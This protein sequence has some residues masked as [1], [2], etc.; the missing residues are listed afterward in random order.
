[1]KNVQRARYA[2]ILLLINHIGFALANVPAIQTREIERY[3][4]MANAEREKAIREGY[5]R[6]MVGMTPEQVKAILGEPDEIRPLHEPVMKNGKQIGYTHWF[7]I[8]RMVKNGSQNDRNESLARVSYDFQ[9]RVTAVNSWGIETEECGALG[10]RACIASASCELEQVAS[11]KYI[12]RSAKN[13]CEVGFL[14]L[15]ENQLVTCELKPGCKYVPANCYCQP[16]FRCRCGGGR[17]SQ[18]VEAKTETPNE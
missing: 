11:N 13:R 18:C 14:Q 16:D 2:L 6:V 17:P 7:V 5:K 3:P 1:M 10:E 8:R 12:C 4:F 15:G 9:N